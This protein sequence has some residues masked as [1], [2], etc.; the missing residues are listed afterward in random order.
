M[1]QTLL[2]EASF[3][4][5]LFRLDEDLAESA[6]AS[7]CA[8]GGRLHQAHY[9]R[10]P[11]GGP[12]GLSRCTSLRLSY[13]CSVDGCRRR[14]TPP[15][16]RFLGRKVFFSVVVLLIPVLREGPKGERLHRL[17]EVFQ[18]SPRTVRRWQ[19]WWREDF[20]CSRGMTRFQ[21]LSAEPVEREDLPGSLLLIFRRLSHA[22][23]R[24]L[25]VLRALLVG[26]S[27]QAQ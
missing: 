20:G 12:L 26:P 11:R 21:G 8:C 18:V 4:Q 2:R 16:L 13:C 19:R 25:A 3:Y 9:Q 1:Y 7:G 6:R 24:V 15:S 22:G 10:K 27:V 14:R 23:E 17:Q 5:L